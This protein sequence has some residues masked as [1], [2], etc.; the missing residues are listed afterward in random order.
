M[1]SCYDVFIPPVTLSDYPWCFWFM[2]PFIFS[3][4]ISSS[5][6]ESASNSRS[7]DKSNFPIFLSTSAATSVFSSQSL[8]TLDRMFENKVKGN[9]KQK[10][11]GFPDFF[12]FVT[13]REW[14]IDDWKIWQSNQDNREETK[15]NLGDRETLS[16]CHVRTTWRELSTGLHKIKC[17]SNN[18]NVESIDRLVN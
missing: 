8:H 18:K 14:I 9:E 6:F 3:F 17:W 11:N 2:K 4:V 15:Q 7:F 13:R 5:S 16:W 10:K 1:L 12:L